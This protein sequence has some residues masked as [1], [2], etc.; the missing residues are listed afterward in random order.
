MWFQF[1]RWYRKQLVSVYVSSI[2]VV[3]M[4]ILVVVVVVPQG[5]RCLRV[6]VSLDIGIVGVTIE[7]GLLILEWLGLVLW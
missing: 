3:V 4:V 2:I 6:S 7:V 1:F 5:Y